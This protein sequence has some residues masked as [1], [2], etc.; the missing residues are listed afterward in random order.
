MCQWEFDH[1]DID[2]NVVLQQ[3]QCSAGGTV[4]TF[5]LDLILCCF[6]RY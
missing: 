4:V 1:A 5:M 2:K 6:N 3:L